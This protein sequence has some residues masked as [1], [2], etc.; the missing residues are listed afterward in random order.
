VIVATI[1]ARMS[2]S[3]LPGKVLKEIDG[4]P[5]IGL[6]ISRLRRSLFIDEILVATSNNANDD[7]LAEYC[8]SQGV[9][10]YRGSEDDVLA[11]VAKSVSSFQGGI[12]VECF[13]DSPLI[14]SEI[15]DFAIE[16]FR[17]KRLGNQVVTNTLKTTF[18]PGMETSVYS[19]KSLLALNEAVEPTDP[20]REHVGMNFSRF[21][22]LF[23]VDNF[24][25]PV[26]L[27]QHNLFL[28]VDEYPDLEVVRQIFTHFSQE[29]AG[30]NFSL[31]DIIQYA[32]KN[33]G[34]F[35]VND[36]IARRWA[37]FRN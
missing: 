15:I 10:T 30:L 3:R 7:P 16:R 19:V 4:T 2:S 33:P 23:K 12:H 27:E 1:Q 26:S 36:K 17:K 29:G 31:G 6:Q 21:P 25:A 32:E 22:N 34:L 14:D 37:K 20:L 24:T 5:M 13:G 28:E 9:K 11:R 8:V 18:P 35:R